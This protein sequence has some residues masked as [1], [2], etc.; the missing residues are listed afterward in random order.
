MRPLSTLFRQLTVLL[1]LASILLLAACDQSPTYLSLKGNLP[2]LPDGKVLL[3]GSFPGKAIDSTLIRDGIFEFKLPA[4]DFPEPIMVS[5]YY[6]SPEGKQKGIV[7]TTGYKGKA[8]FGGIEATNAFMLE[9][10]IEIEGPFLETRNSG[11]PSLHTRLPV[12]TGRQNQVWFS[13]TVGFEKLKSIPALQKLI[14]QHP[15]SYHY[16]Y[17]LERRMHS[18]NKPGFYALYNLFDPELRD[19]PTGKAMREY[20]ETRDQVK[21]TYQTALPDSTGTLQPILKNNSQ[22]TIVTLWTSWCGPCRAEIPVLKRIHDKF[23]ADFSLN[24]V[25]ISVDYEKE[26]WLEALKRE[27]MPWTQLMMNAETNR[28]AKELFGYGNR[29]PLTLFLDREGNIIQSFLGFDNEKEKTFVSLIA[30]HIGPT[31]SAKP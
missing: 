28:Y 2:G 13:D 21:L 29:I 30:Q 26:P 20:I 19:S 16:F 18:A 17:S 25:S 4:K 9:D 31:S 15:Y 23:S 14:R 5:L 12:K 11:I 6:L 8:G 24:L 27:K 10:G 7:V 1:Y 22:L 3:K